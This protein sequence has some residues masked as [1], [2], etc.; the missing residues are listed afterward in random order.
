MWREHSGRRAAGRQERLNGPPNRASATALPGRLFLALWLL[1]LTIRGCEAFGLVGLVGGA[2]V[3]LLSGAAIIW[4]VEGGN[5][6]D[7]D[8]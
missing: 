6:D 7:S 5:S 3:G 4:L 2:F 1:L 8:Q